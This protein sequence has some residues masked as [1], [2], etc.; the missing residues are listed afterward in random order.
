[1]E[2]ISENTIQSLSRVLTFIWSLTLERVN[3]RTRRGKFCK[4]TYLHGNA[5][6]RN[7]EM[8]PDKSDPKATDGHT[9]SC[10]LSP[11]Q[12]LPL[13]PRSPSS[14]SVNTAIRICTPR[15]LC[16]HV[17]RWTNGLR[18]FRFLLPRAR[19]I[20]PLGLICNF[21]YRFG[22]EKLSEV[23]R[24]PEE[25]KFSTRNKGESLMFLFERSELFANYQKKSYVIFCN[26]TNE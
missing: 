13:S 3:I 17:S 2:G 15:I 21:V 23:Y 4:Y 10:P 5:K 25:S 26:L 22:N 7:N 9:R 1:M 12:T 19:D 14:L 20:F 16:L 8:K 6:G 24:L 11:P 18:K